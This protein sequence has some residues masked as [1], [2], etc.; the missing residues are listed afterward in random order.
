MTV[1]VEPAEQADDGVWTIPGDADYT[2][3]W[4]ADGEVQGYY[5]SL[6][7][8]NGNALL[9]AD[10]ATEATSYPLTAGLL[11]AGDYTLRVGAVP[12]DGSDTVWASLSFR[13]LPE[14]VKLAVGISPAELNDENIWVVE[15]NT[16][17]ALNW[18]AEGAIQGYVLNVHDAKGNELLNDA[19]YDE[20][21]YAITAGALSAGDYDFRV[22][23]IPADGGDTVWS[24]L[25]FRILPE[26]VKLAVG[27]SPAELNDENIWVVEPNTG[28]ALNWTAEG[29][30]QGYA[31]NVHDAN[32]NELLNDA[33]YAETSYAIAAGALSAGDYDFRVGAIPADGGDTVW[34]SL[35]FRVSSEPVMLTVNFD[36]NDTNMDRRWIVSYWEDIVLTWSAEGAVQGYL[37]TITDDSDVVAYSVNGVIQ[38]TS[39]TIDAGTLYAGDYTLRLGAVPADGG[40]TVWEDVAFRI[41]DEPIGFNFF[42]YNGEPHGSDVWTVEPGTDYELYWGADGNISGYYVKVMDA[43]GNVVL[44]IDELTQAVSRQMRANELPA[45]D[46]TLQAT[47]VPASSADPVTQFMYFHIAAAQMEMTLGISPADADANDAWIVRPDTDFMLTWSS[48]VPV[49]GYFVDLSSA[50]GLNLQKPDKLMTETSMAF[51]AGQLATGEYI[52]RVEAVPTAGGEAFSQTLRFIIQEGPSTVTPPPTVPA[53]FTIAP[54]GNEGTSEQVRVTGDRVMSVYFLEKNRTLNLHINADQPTLPSFRL[55]LLNYSQQI[56]V[57]EENGYTSD[58]WSIPMSD[59]RLSEGDIYAVEI[60]DG[61]AMF[62]FSIRSA[63]PQPVP[64]GET[65]IWISHVSEI[66][67]YDYKGTEIDVRALGYVSNITLN[68]SGGGTKIFQY[69]VSECSKQGQFQEVKSGVL[70]APTY[71]MDAAFMGFKANTLYEIRVIPYMTSEQGAA[72]YI[73]F[74]S[75]KIYAVPDIKPG[76]SVNP[77]PSVKP[78]PSKDL[79]PTKNKTITKVP[80]NDKIIT[81]T[82]RISTRPPLVSDR[83]FTIKTPIPI[84]T[85]SAG[86][87]IMSTPAPEDIRLIVD[88]NPLSVQ[89]GNA[90]KLKGRIIG[91]ELLDSVLLVNEGD[92]V[93]EQKN[94]GT[95]A[96]DLGNFMVDT[97]SNAYWRD[98]L[99]E[100]VLDVYVTSANAQ[101]LAAATPQP[102]TQNLVLD[103]NAITLQT[104]S[105]AGNAAQPT[106]TANLPAGAQNLGSVVVFVEPKPDPCEGTGQGLQM[107]L[108]THDAAFE[109]DGRVAIP[110][111][112]SDINFQ[113]DPGLMLVSGEDVSDSVMEWTGWIQAKYTGRV[114][115]SVYADNGVRLSVDRRQLI[116][117]WKQSPARTLTSNWMDVISGQKYLIDLTC[118]TGTGG[119]QCAL[120]WEYEAAQEGR[121]TVPLK[122]LYSTSRQLL[123]VDAIN[124][125]VQKYSL[126]PAQADS[127]DYLLLLGNDENI[128][129]AV[130]KGEP[131]IFVLE[132]AGKTTAGSAGS[133]H[134][135]GRMDALL[136]VVHN[137]EVIHVSGS[138]S[139]LPDIPRAGAT[140]LEGSTFVTME[141]IETSQGIE[142]HLNIGETSLLSNVVSGVC[143]YCGNSVIGQNV[144]HI[145]K[146]DR[147]DLRVVPYAQSAID[148]SGVRS[149]QGITLMQSD[150]D[151]VLDLIG[152]QTDREALLVVDRHAMNLD[153]LDYEWLYDNVGLQRLTQK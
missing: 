120:S 95:R 13:M 39:H 10:N 24:L 8:A 69:I 97:L 91:G 44:S 124:A 60:N 37:L 90:S 121:E 9:S 64:A 53:A 45:G 31:L 38:D 25:S 54:I 14:P 148:A 47:A 33:N 55:R 40:E 127:L 7:D 42:I 23:A 18:T 134:S 36:P 107:S 11:P 105:Q 145:C 56:E 65:R 66:R 104:N 139:T 58:T 71:V 122:Y 150:Y 111:I 4:G 132:G 135:F 146:T 119:G 30:I 12:A 117:E 143:P 106:A 73:L 151:R 48:N 57:L 84:V 99:G 98:H 133:L 141:D 82:P 152:Q 67:K 68:I 138:A 28:V 110:L 70:E 87:L 102:V 140:L 51:R 72:L 78:G 59:E 35:R 89:Q 6:T 108:F 88:E 101:N 26:P 144:W 86:Q 79:G 137:G 76:P 96:F 130:E 20:T 80:W 147:H 153:R 85:G 1:Q 128:T 27:I 2:L 41:E 112:E 131:I 81:P 77:G 49:D 115:F 5:V 136:I 74:D 83:S 34:A 52:L 75:E 21:S 126:N 113:W 29:A 62:L 116:N 22:G 109:K 100:T 92:I 19:N 118:F 125:A 142:K 123:S 32:G 3:R 17:V 61:S 103:L 93:F 15:P 149:E 43:D 94:I 46:Y 63:A 114:C 129:R 16:G 50:S